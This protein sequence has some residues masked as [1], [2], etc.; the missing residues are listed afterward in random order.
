MSKEAARIPV[1]SQDPE[2]KKDKER[3]ENNAKKVFN[4]NNDAKETTEEELSEED[5]QLKNDLEMLVERLKDADTSL[6]RP[7]LE[8]L[9]TLIRT[10]TTSMTS[11]P[12]P[13]KF[14][15]P[16]Y[17]EVIGIYESWEDSEDKRLLA[18]ILSLLAMTYS[19][20]GLRMSLKYR[21][22]G[23][24]DQLES[25]GHEYI[26]H[27][28]AEIGQEYASRVENDE[29]CDDL[30]KLA[31]EVVPFFLKHNAEA[32]AVDLLLELEAIE[33]LPEYVDKDTYARVCLYMVSCVSL[34]APPD[35]VLFL[36]T[37]HTI[38]RQQNKLTQA[39]SLSIKLN[40]IE[41][42][43][44][45]FDSCEDPLL[46]KQLAYIL[47]RQQISVETEDEELA[48]CLNNTRLSEHFI[49]LAKELDVMEAKTPEDIYKTHLENVRSGLGGNVDSARQNLASTFVNAF[50]NAGFGSDKLMT[51][52][53]DANSWI[54]KNKEHGMMSASAS[55]GMILLWDVDVG[56]SQ[57]DKYLYSNDDYIKAGALLAI[58]IVNSRVRSETDP[59]YALLQDFLDDRSAPIKIGAI[60]GLGLAYAGSNREDLSELLSPIIS[61]TSVSMEIAGLAALS[62]GLIFVG[63][64]DGDITSTIL[65]TMME[66]DDLQLKETNSR[67]MGLG[68]GLLYLAKQEAAEATLETLKAIEHPIGKQVEV[69]VE[70]CAYAGTGNVLKVQKM[71]HHCTYHLDKEKGE[72]DLHQAFAVLGVALIAMGEDSGAEMS[73]RTFNHLM[74]YGEP[75]IRRA[76]PLALGLLCA[77]N[78]LLNVLDTLSKYSHDNDT[79]VAINAIFAMGLVG[80][81]TNNA[82]LAQ[83]LRQLASYYHKEPN[84]LFMVRIAQGLLH[85]GKGTMTIN[86]IHSD[87]TLMSPTAVAGILSV[88][89]AFTDAKST[90]LSKSHY[91]LYYLVNAMYPRFLITLD[92]NL[93]SFPVTV[94]VGQAVDVVG[95]AGR[96]KTIT[97]FQTHSTPVLLAHSERAE[98]ATEEYLTLSHV[99][100]G[101]VL[102]KKNPDYMDEDTEK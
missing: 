82:R 72:D 92:E 36:K 41:M 38:Y 50:V 62:L 88:L 80:A 84:S 44:D 54:Y 20:D 91:L 60:V 102:L 64:C 56:L 94:R 22:L 79:D 68:L 17:Q 31:F 58:G 61:D 53:D 86:P 81:G 85:M 89:I 21:I 6:Y 59:A 14:L 63:S 37:A 48:E 47:A 46:K 32:D 52:S 12:K 87:R 18:D 3:E 19:D 65:Q 27:L 26:R 43:K 5:Q 99:L 11:V 69:L 73:L 93:K 2:P 75:V 97:G 10:A 40:D 100:E 15:R 76:V 95:Q 4:I 90:I 51:T 35:D 24:S 77:S 25:W 34:L 39:L 78:P 71:L 74:H 96:P 83:M 13:L 70:V 66:R 98:L 23:S 9:R 16:H 49:A 7:S 30:M 67:F 28:A 42:I 55:L 33:K 1:P 29:S 101:F 8:T 45:D 57:I